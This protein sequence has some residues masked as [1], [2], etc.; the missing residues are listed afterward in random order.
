MVLVTQFERVTQERVEWC[1]R[2]LGLFGT[3]A[4]S[5]LMHIWCTKLLRTQ[6]QKCIL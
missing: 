4:I 5:L 2:G 6:N 1:T 3:D